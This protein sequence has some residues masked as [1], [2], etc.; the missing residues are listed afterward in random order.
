MRD[1]ELFKSP[2]ISEFVLFM[3][4]FRSGEE[5]LVVAEGEGSPSSPFSVNPCTSKCGLIS[6]SSSTFKG[7]TSLSLGIPC[8]ISL[9]RNENEGD[10]EDLVDM[11]S[12]GGAKER[13]DMDP[14][15]SLS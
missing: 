14:E 6:F 1:N 15:S 9:F 11:V 7:F 5:T 8:C 13:E 2:L 12:E 3:G 4:E 10:G